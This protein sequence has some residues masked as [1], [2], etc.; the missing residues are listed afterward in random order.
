MQNWSILVKYAQK[1]KRNQL[2][3]TD[4]FLAKFRPEISSEIGQFF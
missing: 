4:C 1:N 3:F 2:F